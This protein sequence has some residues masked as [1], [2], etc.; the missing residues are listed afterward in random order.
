LVSEVDRLQG[1]VQHIK[2]IVTRQQSLSGVSGVLEEVPLPKVIDDALAINA[3]ALQKSGVIVYREFD[4]VPWAT[5]DRVKLTQILVNLI[6]NAEESLAEI[7]GTDRRLTLRTQTNADGSVEIHV[8]D[9]GRGIAPEVQERLFT[10]GFTTKKD[11]HGFGL[12]ASA[13]AAQDMGGT[14]R[15]HSDGVNR[16]ASV[17]IA[18]APPRAVSSIPFAA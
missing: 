18:L 8:I 3:D 6:A 17:I 2:D 13:L 15:A 14:L 4:G 16:G 5:C 10:Y 11:G 9:N 12:H 7:V 1:S